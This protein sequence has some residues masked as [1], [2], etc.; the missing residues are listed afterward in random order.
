MRQS[1]FKNEQELR[2]SI[3]TDYEK[4]AIKGRKSF[5]RAVADP[6]YLGLSPGAACTIYNKGKL[7]GEIPKYM[8][9]KYGFVHLDLAPVCPYC[10]E[11]HTRKTCPNRETHKKRNRRA[12]N[13][14]NALSTAQTV[15]EHRSSIGYVQELADHLTSWLI[16]QG[17]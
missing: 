17:V 12:V 13:L 10:Q 11:V 3:K 6:K 15:I 1:V 14:D 9:H 8:I 4:S 7:D 16:M 2:K 5:R